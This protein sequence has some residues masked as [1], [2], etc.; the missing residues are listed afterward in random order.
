MD[1]PRAMGLTH[2]FHPVERPTKAVHEMIATTR[3]NIICVKMRP[4][5]A[6]S[7]YASNPRRTAA[8]GRYCAGTKAN[9]TSPDSAKEKAQTQSVAWVDAPTAI[10]R[11]S[12]RKDKAG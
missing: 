9:M 8:N 3:N 5:A 6:A 1:S 12:G 10:R 4:D 11:A 7:K 2:R